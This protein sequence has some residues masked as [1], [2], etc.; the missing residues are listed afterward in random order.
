MKN[1]GVTLDKLIKKYGTEEGNRRYKKWKDETNQSLKGFIKRYGEKEGRLKYDIFKNKSLNALKN[2]DHK[3]K[4][5]IRKLNYWLKF[6]NGD[7]QLAINSLKEYQNKST[8]DRF[9]KRYGE[10]DGKKKYLENNVKKAITLEKMIELHGEV[11]GKEKYENWKVFNKNTKDK[12]IKKYGVTEGMIKY[13]D[14]IIKKTKRLKRYSSIG[15]EFCENINSIIKNK[16]KNIY[17]GDNEY[18]FFIFEDGIK[19]ISPDLYIKDINLVI[20]FYGD[21]WHKN[22]LLYKDTESFVKE[23]WDFDN[24]RINELPTN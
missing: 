13:N 16:F 17:Y 9:I 10:V 24:K 11:K 8:L 2:V 21:F 19:I 15:I 12:Y 20:E 1:S 5:S 6:H 4:I 14:L 23:T 18:M 7:E 3:N 22:P